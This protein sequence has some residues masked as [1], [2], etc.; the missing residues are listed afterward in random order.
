[1]QIKGSS[2]ILILVTMMI[3]IVLAALIYQL[4]MPAESRIDQARLTESITFEIVEDSSGFGRLPIS[5]EA[6]L[7]NT[8]KI[9][10]NR[11]TR[12]GFPQTINNG[13]KAGRYIFKFRIEDNPEAIKRLL[14]SHGKLDI[15]E[16]PDVEVL[17]AI[18]DS[19]SSIETISQRITFSK[20]PKD[21]FA[22]AHF[23]DTAI[24][25]SIANA[26]IPKNTK[27]F[28]SKK[29]AYGLPT[30]HEL[31]IVKSRLSEKPA[32]EV[33]GYIRDAKIEDFNTYPGIAIKMNNEAAKRWKTITATNKHKRLV[34]TL[35][36]QVYSAPMVMDEISGGEFVI[37]SDFTKNELKEIEAIL[38]GGILPLN[39]KII[40][41]N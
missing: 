2:S 5:R 18:K 8:T 36:N 3:F 34:I 37:A 6:L 29:P 7:N 25:S 11:L 33:N 38:T 15:W 31:Y 26:Y 23:N 35:D 20:S 28:W 16:T 32:L 14:T 22:V 39:I 19:L 4:F 9:L 40:P 12:F 30:K 27:I 13:N 10:K 41:E 24:I 21:I 1:M 17:I